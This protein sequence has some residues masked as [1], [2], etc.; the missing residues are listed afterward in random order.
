MADNTTSTFNGS[1]L[2]VGHPILFGYQ[3]RRLP[4][5]VT[6]VSATGLLNAMC[7]LSD[8]SDVRSLELAPGNTTTDIPWAGAGVTDSN[9]LP[10]G[11]WMRRL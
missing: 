3:G 5:V 8:S 6:A 2:N 9:L 11:E 7:A 1:T 10:D 4:G